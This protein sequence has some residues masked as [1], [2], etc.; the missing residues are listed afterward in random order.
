MPAEEDAEA[1]YAAGTSL[2]GDLLE[3]QSY[4]FL[5]EDPERFQEEYHSLCRLDGSLPADYDNSVD[6]AWCRLESM[7]RP[8]RK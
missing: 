7:S 3:C 8:H 4:F 6:E 1:V 2:L 5:L